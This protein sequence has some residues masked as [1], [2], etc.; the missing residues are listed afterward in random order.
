L[1]LQQAATLVLD[2]AEKDAV[3]YRQAAY[4]QGIERI[5]QAIM[6]RGNCQ[7]YQ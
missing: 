2:R 4:Y 5:S 6:A 1:C 7:E 3:T